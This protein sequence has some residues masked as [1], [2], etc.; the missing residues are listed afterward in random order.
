VPRTA[1]IAFCDSCETA[2]ART[3]RGWRAYIATGDDGEQSVTIV[4][5]ACAER[6]FGEDEASP[7]EAKWSD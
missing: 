7:G 4:C 2:T 3:E 5:P 6:C 1:A